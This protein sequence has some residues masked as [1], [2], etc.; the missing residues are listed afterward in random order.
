MVIAAISHERY[1][2]SDKPSERTMLA[3]QSYQR[4]VMAPNHVFHRRAVDLRNRFLLLD[5]V[6]NHSSGRA[7]NQA[8]GS[9][10]EDFVSL[11]RRLDRLDN[12]IR[13]IA[14]FD[15]LQDEE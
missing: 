9:T 6:Q 1:I 14:N 4:G 15:E 5:V 13:Q 10:V 12:R 7:K 8:G 11:D 2:F 3:H